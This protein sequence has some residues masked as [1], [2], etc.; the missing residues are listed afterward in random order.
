M[1]HL[2]NDT[3]QKL[4]ESSGGTFQ[5]YEILYILDLQDL[6]TS[7]LNKQILK[8]TKTQCQIDELCF[9]DSMTKMIIVNAPSC[10]PIFWRIVK[11]WIDPRNAA[12]VEI[13]G[14][15]R[16]QW[17]E[18]IFEF[19]ER[20]QLPSDYGG[21]EVNGTSVD[22]MRQQMV[23]QYKLIYPEYE[24]IDEVTNVMTFQRQEAC[25]RVEVKEG[26]KLRLSI[27]TNSKSGG[28]LRI[29]DEDG[30][31]IDGIPSQGIKL[32]HTSAGDE[33]EGDV[34]TSVQPTKYDLKELGINLDISGFYDV[35]IRLNERLRGN[36]L[37]VTHYYKE[38][39]KEK[40]VMES[41]VASV[42]TKRVR[43]TYRRNGLKSYSLGI[44]TFSIDEINHDDDQVE[45]Y[46]YENV[47]EC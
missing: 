14:T 22:I 41:I 32:I 6:S 39:K 46:P 16:A 20:D 34:S 13:F 37:L 40:K 8:I 30:N 17:E 35:K 9:P 11:A 5:R 42:N 38:K 31:F 33:N 15:N 12:K 25:Q 4:Y 3:F 26:T 28:I 18:R 36:F 43:H 29:S 10:F 7:K 44:G 27:Y 24:M 45:F 2:R 21:L 47:C 23:E 19:V 1:F